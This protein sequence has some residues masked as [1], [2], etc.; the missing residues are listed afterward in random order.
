VA[1]EHFLWIENY[2]NVLSQKPVLERFLGLKLEEASEGKVVFSTKINSNQCNF[3][4]FVHG[5]ALAS[6][7]EI[8]M[9]LACISMGKLVVTLDLNTNYIK[10]APEGSVLT[11]IGKVVSNGNTIMRATG[12]IVNGEQVLVRSQASY[13]INGDFDTNDYPIS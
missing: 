4:G 8:T 13:Y 9:G 1:K 3:Y 5:A 6:I 12:K 7:L 11:A 2:I 10:N